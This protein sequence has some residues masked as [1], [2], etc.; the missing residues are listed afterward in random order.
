MEYF[1]LYFWLNVN[2]AVL[3]Y[4]TVS[5][6]CSSFSNHTCLTMWEQCFLPYLWGFGVSKNACSV[7][8]VFQT[9]STTKWELIIVNNLK[10]LLFVLY[11]MDTHKNTRKDTFSHVSSTGLLIYDPSAEEPKN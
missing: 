8:F 4:L 7:Q 6:T 11:L 1:D 9:Q 10:L 5:P 2:K 3:L